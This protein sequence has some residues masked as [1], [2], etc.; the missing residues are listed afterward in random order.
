MGDDQYGRRFSGRV[1]V[2]PGSS[3]NPSIGRS[4]AVRL[5]LEGASVVING[6]DPATLAATERALRARGIGVVAVAGSMEDDG[7]PSRLVEAA[8]SISAGSTIW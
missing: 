1:A 3:A 5:G 2:V 6:R 4:C 7:T 8:R